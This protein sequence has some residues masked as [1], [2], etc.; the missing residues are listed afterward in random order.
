MIARFAP[1]PLE[2]DL[3]G[4]SAG[5]KKALATLIEAARLTNDVFLDQLWSG[6]TALYHKLEQDKSPLGRAR[7]HYFWINKGPWS[8]IDE[9]KAF[10]PGVPA[11]KPLGANFYPEDMTKEEFEVWAKTLYPES[12]QA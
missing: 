3:S 8:E 5:D 6:N 2:V 10:L 4:L 9:H 1:A 7:L 12:K 11:K